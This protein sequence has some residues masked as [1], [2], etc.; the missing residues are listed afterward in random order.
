MKAAAIYIYIY[1]YVCVC[2]CVCVCVLVCVC[3]Y[4]VIYINRYIYIYINRSACGMSV[5]GVTELIRGSCYINESGS[6]TNESGRAGSANAAPPVQIVFWRENASG[7][8][9]MVLCQPY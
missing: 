5:G 9:S 7:V 4:I 8:G 1:T 3:I 2:V 6:Y